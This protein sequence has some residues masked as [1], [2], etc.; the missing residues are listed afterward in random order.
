MPREAWSPIFVATP[1]V[2]APREREPTF[3]YTALRLP[4]SL[5]SALLLTMYCRS[6]AVLVLGLAA[7]ALTHTAVAA[8][9][10]D[11]ATRSSAR[12]VAMVGVA[13]LQQGNADVA[14]EK[15]E[16]AFQIL[17]VPSVGLWLARALRKRGQ[18]VE[19]SEHYLEASR[20]T[21]FK[22]GETRAR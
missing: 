8:D 2:L 19:A 20:L 22:G 7:L 1:P 5:R 6:R 13:A 3:A 15:L 21:N 16:K 17:R 11:A 4:A 18:L 12:K 14:A 10:E 9:D